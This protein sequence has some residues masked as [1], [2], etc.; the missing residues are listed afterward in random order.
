MR[1]TVQSDGSEYYEYVLL[2]TDDVLFTSNNGESILHDEIGKYFKLKEA[3][4]GLYLGGLVRK[5]DLS[6]NKFYSFSSSQY[7]QS[8]VS[9]VEGSVKKWELVCQLELRRL[10]QHDTVLNQ[11][12]YLS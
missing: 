12:Y 1:P 6:C 5:V 8:D 7:V 3:S 10:A 2:Y 11:T 9:N 4:I